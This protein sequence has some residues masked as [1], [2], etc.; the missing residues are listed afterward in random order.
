MNSVDNGTRVLVKP[1]VADLFGNYTVRAVSPQGVV[2]E[3][4]TLVA[5]YGMHTC[6]VHPH[7]L[8]PAVMCTVN[9]HQTTM[10]C[11][12]ALSCS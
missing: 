1:S 2:Y 5:A 12:G 11:I 8:V 3:E 6:N 7:A 4:W 10:W 9:V